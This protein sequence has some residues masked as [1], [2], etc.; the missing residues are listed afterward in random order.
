MLYKLSDSDESVFIRILLL[1]TQDL[2]QLRALVHLHLGP[3]LTLEDCLVPH[4]IN[5]VCYLWFVCI[6]YMC[7]S[8]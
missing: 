8:L 3:P 5:L 7:I 1:Q 2:G 6:R 4:R